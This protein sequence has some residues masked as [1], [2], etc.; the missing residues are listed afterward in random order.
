M[1]S[2]LNIHCVYFI[3]KGSINILQLANLKGVRLSTKCAV[4]YYPSHSIGRNILLQMKS[5]GFEQT[6]IKMILLSSLKVEIELFC[7]NREVLKWQKNLD[8]A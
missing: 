5:L 3:T 7:L 8:G 6:L 1:T 4:K 2:S